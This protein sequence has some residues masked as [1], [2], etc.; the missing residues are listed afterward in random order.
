MAVSSC[1]QVVYKEF[2]FPHIGL[3]TVVTSRQG[4]LTPLMIPPLVYPEIRVCPVLGFVPSTGLT[5]LT[6]VLS[7]IMGYAI[8]KHY[9][10][11]FTQIL[12]MKIVSLIFD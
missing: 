3:M 7:C 11:M 4:I 5:R 1:S 9:W 2:I 10:T 8:I 12:K 6:T